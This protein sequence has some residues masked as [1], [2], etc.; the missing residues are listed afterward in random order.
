VLDDYLRGVIGIAGGQ[1]GGDEHD[2]GQSKPQAWV[3]RV[4]IRAHQ[5]YGQRHVVQ[6]MAA[7]FAPEQLR[8]SA[9]EAVRL[10]ACISELASVGSQ[11]ATRAASDCLDLGVSEFSATLS[12]RHVDSRS[13]ELRVLHQ[14][15]GRLIGVLNGARTKA[16]LAQM[17]SESGNPTE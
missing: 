12:D 9:V 10:S 14:R 2:G 15:L 17:R 5:P 1:A 6:G 3:R 11:L 13:P 16:V 4:L 7:M 8:K